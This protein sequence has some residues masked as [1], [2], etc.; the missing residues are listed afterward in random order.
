M[1]EGCT[2]LLTQARC[3]PRNVQRATVNVNRD[4]EAQAQP[5]DHDQLCGLRES[6]DAGRPHRGGRSVS[7]AR[8][9]ASKLTID[10]GSPVGVKRSSA[11]LTDRY[12]PG[13]LIGRLVVA[14]VNFPPR[15]IGPFMSDVLTLGV[16]DSNG[17]VILLAPHSEVPLGGKVF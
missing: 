11:Q 2:L 8:K 9:P 6:R 1:R 14:V 7:E 12:K 15:Q 4:I 3:L 13:D 5:R 10:F 17:A 16:P